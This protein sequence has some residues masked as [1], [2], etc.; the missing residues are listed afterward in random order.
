MSPQNLLILCK[1]IK[2]FKVCNYM[3]K[4]SAKPSQPQEEKSPHHLHVV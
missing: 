3:W 4:G 2:K 1:Y